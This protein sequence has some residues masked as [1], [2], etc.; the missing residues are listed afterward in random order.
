MTIDLSFVLPC[1][2]EADALPEVLP[3]LL[4]VVD[5]IQ[6][7]GYASEV[8]IVDDA[9]NDGSARI[10]QSYPMFQRI[11]LPERTGYGGSL[12]KGFEKAQGKWV[13]FFD[14]DRTYHPED[15]LD[16]FD[17]ARAT[18]AD[19]VLGYRA[20][21]NSDMPFI[22]TLGNRAFVFACRVLFQS[23]LKDM[24]T[25]FRIIKRDRVRSVRDLN[26]EGFNFTIQLS[27]FALLKGWRLEQIPIR[28][29]ERLGTSKLN[30]V[31]D[32]LQFLKVILRYRWQ[33]T[34]LF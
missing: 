7:R 2:N 21:Q 33:Q 4:A 18:D 6:Q 34:R 20:F 22:R 24:C 5:Q 28:Y 29:E 31:R 8:L 9:S 12:K 23:R 25:G 14:V 13:V 10:I 26:C 27:L 16:L 3:R 11:G 32:G 15:V 19:L 30:A 1:H 17:C